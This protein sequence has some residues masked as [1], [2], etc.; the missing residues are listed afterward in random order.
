MRFIFIRHAYR[1]T[2]DREEDNG[3]TPKGRE[4]VEGLKNYLDTRCLSDPYFLESSFLW[5]SSP[6]VRCQETL[7]PMAQHHAFI[8]DKGTYFVTQKDFKDYRDLIEIRLDERQ[9]SESGKQ[10]RKRIVSLL[11]D[12]HDSF[13]TKAKIVFMC[14][15]G[16]W[17][18]EA[19]S[20]LDLDTFSIKKGS[21]IEVEIKKIN[22]VLTARLFKYIPEP[23]LLVK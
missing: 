22:D 19:L 2:W 14:T 21:W 13:E 17:L 10:F 11:N 6:K 12:C 16:D 4:Q 8:R 5:R 18:E 3:L 7:I 23:L 9:E 20:L 1:D 15:H